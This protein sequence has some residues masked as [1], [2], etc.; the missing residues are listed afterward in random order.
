MAGKMDDRSILRY[1]GPIIF[2]SNKRGPTK[3]LYDGLHQTVSPGKLITL[4]HINV[5]IFTTFVMIV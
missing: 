1:M 5:W 3:H 4:G 2:P